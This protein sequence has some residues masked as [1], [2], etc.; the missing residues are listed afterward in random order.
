MSKED[1]VLNNLQWLKP[2]QTKSYIFD[3]YLYIG[4]GNLDWCDIKP[5][6]STNQPTKQTNKQTAIIAEEI[7]KPYNC[8]QKITSELIL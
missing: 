7:L 5:N 2:N 8:W 1:L 3:I 4:F 6:Q